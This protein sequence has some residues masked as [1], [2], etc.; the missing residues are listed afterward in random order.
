M[1][2]VSA[3]IVYA[4]TLHNSSNIK[5]VQ[6]CEM[7]FST[8]L[9]HFHLVHFKTPMSNLTPM[10]VARYIIIRNPDNTFTKAY[11]KLSSPCVSTLSRVGNVTNNEILLGMLKQ[12]IQ[13]FFCLHE[14]LIINQCLHERASSKLNYSENVA[15][16]NTNCDLAFMFRHTLFQSTQANG[17]ILRKQSLFLCD[18]IKSLFFRDI[19]PREVQTTPPINCADARC[20]LRK[21]FPFFSKFEYDTMHACFCFIVPVGTTKYAIKLETFRRLVGQYA[22]EDADIYLGHM[23]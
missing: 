14:G 23:T 19:K 5:N 20:A 6:S 7:G 3:D 21:K 16:V 1:D 17:R 18:V 12:T 15:S 22:S 9:G 11:E 2:A 10:N 4:C 13:Y 8:E